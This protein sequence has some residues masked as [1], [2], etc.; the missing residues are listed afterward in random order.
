MGRT[1]YKINDIPVPEGTKAK[2]KNQ[3]QKHFRSCPI[4]CEEVVEIGWNVSE[5]SC[6]QNLW[7]KNDDVKKQYEN[8]KVFRCK[9]KTLVTYSTVL[10][11]VYITIDE[12]KLLVV[13][14]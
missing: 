10:Q 11:N 13:L 8:Y 4:I 12:K 9:Q 14:V 7:E 6:A 5:K 2:K 3:K 1:I